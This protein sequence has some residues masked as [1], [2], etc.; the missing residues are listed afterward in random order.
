MFIVVKCCMFHS[1]FYLL[2]YYLLNIII[3]NI[4]FMSSLGVAVCVCVC[5]HAG[6]Y[7]IGDIS[8]NELMF[9]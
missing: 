6:P 5:L 3:C 8:M 2:F 7:I 9:C 1:F 4:L